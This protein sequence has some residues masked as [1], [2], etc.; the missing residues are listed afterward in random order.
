MK[1]EYKIVHYSKLKN[2][3]SFNLLGKE[4]WDLVMLHDSESA[5][6]FIFKRPAEALKPP[7][8]ESLHATMVKAIK[9]EEEIICDCHKIPV[10]RFGVVSKMSESQIRAD[11]R[12]RLIDELLKEVGKDVENANV[13]EY[14]SG[15]QAE[16]AHVKT[17]I[18]SKK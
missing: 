6:E 1:Y 17:I 3:S 4:G 18:N 7:Q 10:R 16:R 8:E 2:A 14:F 5:Y 11:E 13:S 12:E 15:I 9:A